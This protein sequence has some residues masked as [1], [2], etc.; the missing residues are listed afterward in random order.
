M[1]APEFTQ[2]ALAVEYLRHAAPETVYE[3]L[4]GNAGEP[5][6][7]YTSPFA[8]GFLQILFERHDPLINLALAQVVTDRG[9]LASLWA[10]DNLPVRMAIAGNRY[11]DRSTFYPL[12]WIS[13]EDQIAMFSA[14]DISVESDREFL[15]AWFS[16]PVLE[17]ER[18]A[19][20]IGRKGIYA[21][22][23]E[24]KWKQTVVW[25][26]RNP[27]VA[28]TS[29]FER[30]APD[31]WGMYEKGKPIQAAWTLLLSAPNT[32]EWAHILGDPMGSMREFSPPVDM[33]NLPFL[34]QVFARWSAQASNDPRAIQSDG[35]E[36]RALAA[37]RE[38]VA[39]AVPTFKADLQAYLESNPDLAVRRG[40]YR[41]FEPR[42]VAVLS[43][44]WGRDGKEFLEGAVYNSNL[45]RSWPKG[46]RAELKRLINH[47]DEDQTNPVPFE[48]RQFLRA[49]WHGRAT[50]LAKQD[51]SR[52]ADPDE[53]DE[54]SPEATLTDKLSAIQG[55][56][57][58]LARDA[59]RN[60][61]PAEAQRLVS[62]MLALIGRMSV[63][64][65]RGVQTLE[66]AIE[67]TFDRTKSD[68][69]K[70]SNLLQLFSLITI[71]LLA[72]L[73]F[74]GWR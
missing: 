73:V 56:I 52:Y 21:S 54:V 63:E 18:L 8:D 13:E 46:V 23:E 34:Q 65:S 5:R 6:G 41:S 36:S 61:S 47:S 48:E 12:K 45:Y 32:V 28:A 1:V 55:Q 64:M 7:L 72:I 62:E 4:I 70:V 20:V 22:L 15:K 66:Q 37:L 33:G 35:K 50:A 59:A 3:W 25:A 38:N 67:R 68:L 10:L 49:A 27:N 44:Y 29:D 2:P 14:A 24:E 42:D 74:R 17:G 26:V 53:E 16:N 69:S 40:Y 60:D 51:R 43:T 71:G 30:F 11:R 57:D 9:L 31:G 19:D 58:R 39:A